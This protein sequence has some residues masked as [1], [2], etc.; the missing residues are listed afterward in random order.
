MQAPPAEPPALPRLSGHG[1][2]DF[3]LTFVGPAIVRIDAGD[4]LVRLGGGHI[5][6]LEVVGHD[7]VGAIRDLKSKRVV[8]YALDNPQHVLL[9]IAMAHVGLDHRRDIT[10]V[11]QSPAEALRT[12]EQRKVDVIVASLKSTDLCAVEPQD[13]ARHLVDRGL[14]NRYEYALQTMKDVPYQRWRDDD[15]DDTVRL[16]GLRLHEAAMVKS[17]P[18]KI[19]AQGTDWRFLNELKNELK[20]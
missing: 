13:A 16:Y 1:R 20:G 2:G 15:P 9:A 12:F 6:C 5:G 18:Q 14:A 11:T 8:I 4:P 17:G 10:L 3:T 19:L 7:T